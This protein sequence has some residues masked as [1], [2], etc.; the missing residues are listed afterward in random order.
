MRRVV[1]ESDEEEEEE[2]EGVDI[3]HQRQRPLRAC[4]QL[5]PVYQLQPPPEP[6]EVP[7]LPRNFVLER[8]PTRALGIVLGH[9]RGK[10]LVKYYIWNKIYRN[11]NLNYIRR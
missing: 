8:K 3:S 2:E 4:R 10:L 7:R 9:E 1:L 11:L 5:Q 6:E